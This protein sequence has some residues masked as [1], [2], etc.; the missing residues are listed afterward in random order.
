[1]EKFA[2]FGPQTLMLLTYSE[3]SGEG[4]LFMTSTKI[5]EQKE[6]EDKQKAKEGATKGF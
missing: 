1:M 3:I 6:A 4:T 5:I 2:W